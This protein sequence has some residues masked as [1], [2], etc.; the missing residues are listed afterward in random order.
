MFFHL[1]CDSDKHF[2]YTGSYI[3]GHEKGKGS[4]VEARAY[5]PTQLGSAFI[6]VRPNR[7]T[8]VKGRGYNRFNIRYNSMDWLK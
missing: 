8:D 7:P 2:C 3:K 5:P 4:Y 1:V 6:E